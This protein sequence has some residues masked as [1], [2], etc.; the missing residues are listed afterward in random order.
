MGRAVGR[1][2]RAL[3]QEAHGERR[4]R[5]AGLLA[6]LALLAMAVAAGLGLA[7]AAAQM[8]LGWLLEIL[9]VAVLLAQRSLFAHVGRV[10][11][12]LERSLED[13]RQAV[14]MIVGRDPAVLD[15]A[16]VA[17]AAIESAAE[18]YSDGVVAPAFWYLLLGLPGILAYKAIN[19]AD[20]MI[21]HRTPRHRAF[22][23]AAARV[24]D[25][26][27]L[28]P[29][30][31]CPLLIAPAALLVRRRD[32]GPWRALRAAWRDA[33]S[34]RSPNAGWPEAAMAGAL[35]LALAGPRRYGEGWVDDAIQN[36]GGDRHATPDDI[37]AAIRLLAIAGAL[38]AAVLLVL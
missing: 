3:N 13:G 33:G 24:D 2:D 31:L 15:R 21:G 7:W 34:H 19:T 6:V 26:L 17:R 16:G 12:G 37:R 1:L 11:A 32:G 18:N 9:V 25:V 14:A 20:S 27:N 35:G 5:L 8:P 38:G 36:E 23:W 29:A 22:G 4:R 30:R 28:V 10:A